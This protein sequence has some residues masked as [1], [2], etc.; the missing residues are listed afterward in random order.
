MGYRAGAPGMANRPVPWRRR[1]L[2][3]TPEGRGRGSLAGEPVFMDV[4]A[5]NGE[6]NAWAA[7][8]GLTPQR[9]LTRMGRGV[10]VRDDL[11]RYWASFGPEKG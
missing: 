7:D 4:P 3:A 5:A 11:T 8:L 2:P 9:R 1:R 6:A 10:P